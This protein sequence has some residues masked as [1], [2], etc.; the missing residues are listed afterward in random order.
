MPPDR[1]DI[2]IVAIIAAHN[3]ADVIGHV[4]RD[5]VD[6]R[7]DVYLLD[8]RSTDGTVAAVEAYRGR[9]VIAVEQL[10]ET[11]GEP[12]H[13]EFE[14]ERILVRKAQVACELDADWFIHHDADEFRES[15]W[16][17][18]T[19]RDGVSR[20]DALGYNAIDFQ[21]YDFW[22][23]HDRYAAGRDVRDVFTHYSPAA[24]YDRV[25]IRCWKKTAHAV[26]LASSGGHDARFPGRRVFP[27]RFILRHY[28]IR[29]Q[30]QGER[31]V[32]RERQ[33]Q[34]AAGERAR[35]WHV[36]YDS[37]AEGGSFIRDA[38]SLIAYDPD[39]VRIEVALGHRELE[40]AQEA[41][42]ALRARVDALHVEIAAQ[43]EELVRRD[44]EIERRG[45]E[46]ELRGHEL[47]RRGQEIER[48]GQ[49]I[50]RCREEIERRDQEV[51]RRGNEMERRRAE[52]A[53]CVEQIERLVADVE[54]RDAEITTCNAEIRRRGAEI[55]R[56]RTA[57]DDALGQIAQYRGS[58]S[59][60]WT[61]PMRALF[62]RFPPRSQ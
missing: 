57:L 16:R 31:K 5:L 61:A 35:G 30:A 3:E 44:R 19:F 38:A 54:A 45:R 41:A 17:P 10:G 42:A 15:P 25:Q 50:E 62:G 46:I 4:V 58:R 23:I 43:R 26:D 29:S 20:V 28:P 11:F 2:R 48:R 49:E 60:R 9:G 53:R 8:D 33:Q 51:E 52:I 7:I 6:Q 39:Q 1:A 34:F 37:L 21:S 13:N 40:I 27:V 36:Q 14:W 12:A 47:E 55:E 59:W 24:P 22:P 56:W 18:L 32:F